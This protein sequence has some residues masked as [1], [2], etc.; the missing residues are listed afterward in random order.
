MYQVILAALLGGILL[1]QGSCS[2]STS[3]PFKLE[4]AAFVNNAEIPYKYTYCQPDAKGRI[5]A[6]G[7]ISPPLSWKMRLAALSRL[8]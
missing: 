4:S 5:K 6:G 7:D 3:A 8:F 1:I 2:R